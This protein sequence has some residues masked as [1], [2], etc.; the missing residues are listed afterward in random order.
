MRKIILISILL[1]IATYFLG[2]AS[3]SEVKKDLSVGENV[4]NKT[5]ATRTLKYVVRKGDCLWDIAKKDNIYGDPFQWPLLFK[6]NRDQ[7][8]DPDIIEIGQQLDVRKDYSKAE[9]QDAIQKAKDT[10]P[11]VPHKKP[12][13]KLPLKY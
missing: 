13:K 4:E 12:R 7:I 5:E 11:Y 1:F 9:I 8:E 2:C 10:P 6:A 3:R